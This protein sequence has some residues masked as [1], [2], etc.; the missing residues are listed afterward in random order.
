MALLIQAYP[1]KSSAV[2]LSYECLK[3]RVEGTIS[4]E[5]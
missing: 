5:L 3:S 1:A 2:L 4:V